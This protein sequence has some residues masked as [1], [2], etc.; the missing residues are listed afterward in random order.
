MEGL[1]I[2][3]RGIVRLIVRISSTLKSVFRKKEN[4]VSVL[5]IENEKIT[6]SCNNSR[7]RFEAAAYTLCL[8]IYFT[9]F[10]FYT[11]HDPPCTSFFF[12]RR[13]TARHVPFLSAAHSL[14]E[15]GKPLDGRPGA[16]AIR[17]GRGGKAISASRVRARHAAL[18]SE[19]S[20][21]PVQR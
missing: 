15:P 21:A 17:A 3:F 10:E 12:S 1:Y 5:G 7:S 4:V 20:A 11:T 8:C 13:P 2:V 6:N 19:S 9:I 18:F 16:E 14:P